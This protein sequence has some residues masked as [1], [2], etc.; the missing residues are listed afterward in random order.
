LRGEPLGHTKF[1]DILAEQLQDS[2]KGRRMLEMVKTR[3]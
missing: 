3:S 2:G 1:V